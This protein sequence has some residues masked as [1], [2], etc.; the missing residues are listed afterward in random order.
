M[1]D[2]SGIEWSW[3]TASVVL[4]GA[5]QARE[6]NAVYIAFFLAEYS[7][8]KVIVTHVLEGV[9]DHAFEEQFRRDLEELAKR[10][11]VQYEYVTID[12]PSKPPG[13]D[14]IARSI[15]AAANANNAQAIVMSAHREPLFRELFGRVSDHVARAT[16]KRVVLVETPRLGISVP[17]NP[18][19]IFIPV[20][21]E[22]HAEPFVVAAALTSSASVPEVEIIVAKIVELPPTVPLDA[23]EM[24]QSLKR[25]ERDFSFFTSTAIK[26]LG[27]LFTP[28]IL[29]VRE[30]GNDVSQFIT[31]RG[32]DLVVMYSARETGFHGFLTK[33]EYEIVSSSPS[34]VLV[35]LASRVN[36]N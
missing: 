15:V 18:K 3:S 22:V 21:K 35:T 11:S 32:I 19:R 14:E 5:F 34:I 31:D 30:V 28:K 6:W 8:S 10:L 2:D 9:E 20:L 24:S 27:R 25:D 1:A 13:V 16:E 7:G 33:D 26:S 4:P 12:P 17:K 36:A 29:P 23:V